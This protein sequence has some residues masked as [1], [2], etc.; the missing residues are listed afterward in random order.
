M[1]CLRSTSGGVA[2]AGVLSS[3]H[4]DPHRGHLLRSKRG[5]V[6]RTRQG[7]GCGPKSCARQSRAVRVEDISWFEILSSRVM[8]RSCVSYYPCGSKTH[9]E[10]LSTSSLSPVRDSCLKGLSVVSTVHPPSPPGSRLCTFI[11]FQHPRSSPTFIGFSC[12]RDRK[13]RQLVQQCHRFNHVGAVAV[14]AIL[15]YMCFQW[16]EFRS[17]V[18]GPR[19]VWPPGNSA[20]AEDGHL[21]ALGAANEAEPDQVIERAGELRPLQSNRGCS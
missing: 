1:G 19:L 18:S 15:L 4:G 16:H 12:S 9:P 11:G 6:V 17:G 14:L 13:K 5:A 3:R 2:E 21:H 8:F 10:E 20:A 7:R